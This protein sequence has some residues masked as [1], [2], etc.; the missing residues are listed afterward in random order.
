MHFH[1]LRH[2]IAFAGLT[3]GTA[4]MAPP[5]QSVP[6]EQAEACLMAQFVADELRADIGRD[7]GD[8]VMVRNIQAAGAL[9]AFDLGLPIPAGSL[10][11]VQKRVV[12]EAASAA[13]VEGFC[14]N[15]RAEEVF[16]F[17]NQFQLRSFG[18][19][20]V[21]MGASTLRSCGG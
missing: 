20:G 19:D 16:Q 9:V 7:I 10:E 2:S 1:F 11:L 6:C 17:G 8:G 5:P 18:T 13:F 14:G 15:P 21:L 4:C 3:L 12:H